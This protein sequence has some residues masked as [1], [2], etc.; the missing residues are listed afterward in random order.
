MSSIGTGGD[1]SE[2]VTPS[3]APPQAAP[4]EAG[5]MNDAMSSSR[6]YS[7]VVRHAQM[8]EHRTASRVDRETSEWK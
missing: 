4:Q 6:L 1:P 8:G 2:I 5:S 7:G 3:P